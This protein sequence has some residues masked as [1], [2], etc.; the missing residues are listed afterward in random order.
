MQGASVILP[1]A[2]PNAP[3]VRWAAGG[4]PIPVVPVPTDSALVPVID[5]EAAAG[6]LVIMDVEGSAN[7]MTGR[8]LARADL[9]LVPMQPSSLDIEEARRT[10]ALIREEAG[11]GGRSRSLSCW[12]EHQRWP[13]A[14]STPSS[15]SWIKGI[16]R[17]RSTLVQRAVLATLFS[18]RTT[19]ANLEPRQVASLDYARGNAAEFDAEVVA[20]LKAIVARGAA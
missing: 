9:V 12:F 10:I 3:P 2:V 15:R 11:A 6:D 20:M 4:H 18:K 7:R 5:R 16:P 19:L 13:A 1:D 17:L 14:T 8:A